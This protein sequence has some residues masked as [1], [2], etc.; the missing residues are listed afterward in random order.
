MLTDLEIYD[1]ALTIPLLEKYWFSTGIW[2]IDH[3]VEAL[4]SINE[5]KNEDE[6]REAL[7]GALRQLLSN[8]PLAKTRDSND[9]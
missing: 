5:V 6:I 9:L 7:H 4:S 8:L 1:L 3:Y 2:A